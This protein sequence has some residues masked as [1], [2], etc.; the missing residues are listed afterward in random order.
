M[1]DNNNKTGRGRKSFTYEKEMEDIFGKKRNFYPDLLLDTLAIHTPVT[2]QK[3]DTCREENIVGVMEKR[4]W[5]QVCR[6]VR[7]LKVVPLIVSVLAH[8]RFHL[9]E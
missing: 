5:R 2:P 9:K 1:V 4:L 7:I 3:K 6:N 8:Q